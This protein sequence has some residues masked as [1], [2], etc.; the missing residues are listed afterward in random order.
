MTTS[1]SGDP[2]VPRGTRVDTVAAKYDVERRSREKFKEIARA[3]GYS[4]PGFFDALV[5]HMP[6][7]ENGAP[8]FVPHNP[9]DPRLKEGRLL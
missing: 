3:A 2:R 6:L 8:T 4:A 5:E 7:D 9:H 1:L